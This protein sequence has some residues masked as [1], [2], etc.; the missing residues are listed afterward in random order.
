MAVEDVDGGAHGTH[1]RLADPDRGFTEFAALLGGL[2]SRRFLH[3]FLFEG[4]DEDLLLLADVVSRWVGA[5]AAK[6]RRQL[7]FRKW[8]LLRAVDILVGGS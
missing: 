8:T 4:L 5:T 1:L 2:S 6:S 7:R 3:I